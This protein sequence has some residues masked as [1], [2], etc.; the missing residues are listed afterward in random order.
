MQ[1]DPHRLT[2]Q[3]AFKPASLSR[4][5]AFRGLSIEAASREMKL[6]RFTLDRA[7]NGLPLSAMSFGKILTYLAEH[8]EIEVP[9]GLIEEP[10]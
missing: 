10:A 7:L 4:A 9:D 5:L 1:D 8:P 3:H 2:A 6:S